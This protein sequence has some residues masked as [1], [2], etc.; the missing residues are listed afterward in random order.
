MRGPAKPR[1]AAWPAYLIIS[2]MLLAGC[3][4]TPSGPS[5]SGSDAAGGTLRLLYDKSITTW[6]PQRMYAGPEGALA[7]RLFTR[8]LTGYPAGG[9]GGVDGL[10]GDLATDTGTASDG[11]KTWSFTLRSGPAWEDGRAVTCADVA[12]G[13]ARSFARDQLPGG[14]AYPMTL[15]DIPSRVDASGHDVP[16]YRGPYAA[17]PV[18]TP[19]AAAGPAAATASPTAGG[20]STDAVTSSATA[21][22]IQVAPGVGSAS[23]DAAVTCQGPKLTIR[24]KVPVPDF[25]Q[26]VAL[27]AFAPYRQDQ[28]RGASG[29]FEVFSCGPYRL[30]GTWEA[31]AGGRFVRNSAWDR[32]GDALRQALP[33][34]IDIRESIPLDLLVQRL[35][36]DKAPDHSAIGLTDLPS[37]RHSALLADPQIKARASNPYSGTV[38]LLQPNVKSPVMS[39]PEVRRALALATD[40]EGFA[41]A[42]GSTVMTPAYAALAASIPG[43]PTQRPP[44][45]S[46]T[47]DPVAARSALVASG[48]SLPVHIRVA[49]RT[50][51]AADAAYAALKAGWEKAGFEVELFGLGE[52]YYRLVSAPDASAKYDVFRRSWFADYPAGAAVIPELF[53]GRMNISDTGTGQDLGSFT[54]AAVNAG[55]DAAQ[56]Q[57]DP[58]MRAQAWG[59]IDSKVAALGGQ[60]P[61]A[62]RRRFFLYGSAVVGYAENPYLGGWVDLAAVA[63][64]R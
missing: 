18:G 34:V 32:T 25:P 48:L 60:V 58:T 10:T 47:G 37:G 56:V 22:S 50:S 21:S 51:P 31:G 63:V 43:R 9:A 12:Y 28:D 38:E 41:A 15:L 1:Y 14:S 49:Y 3:T 61:L 16:D 39:K 13:I 17:A 64:A 57:A 23:F 19:S 7:V 45:A 40:R 29:T 52:D 30:D 27:P 24:L 11:G 6:D 59:A 8:T 62:E 4:S 53:D 36:E 44:D 55:I 33:D 54:D 20:S 42:Y 35:V 46:P 2:I 26:I 5:P